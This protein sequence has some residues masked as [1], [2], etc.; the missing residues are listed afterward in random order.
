MVSLLRS[1]QENDRSEWRERR[2]AAPPRQQ[3][4]V[5]VGQDLVT[6]GQEDLDDAIAQVSNALRVLLELGLRRTQ[7][8][9]NERSNAMTTEAATSN[10][11]ERYDV[12][13]VENFESSA[14]AEKSSWSRVGVAFPHKDGDGI[15]VELL[16]L[17]VNGK[18]VIRRHGLK[19]RV[20]DSSMAVEP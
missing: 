1:V 4:D 14:G 7:P 6:M 15:N 2:Y 16:A 18:L 20:K 13:V 11:S 9:I 8:L 19:S 10:S 5:A 12:F 17:P 3:G